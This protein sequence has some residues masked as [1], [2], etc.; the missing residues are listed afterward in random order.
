MKPIVVSVIG[1]TAVGKSKLGIEIS[2]RFGGEVINGD[3]MQFYQ[4]FNIG[5]AKVTETEADGVPH[6]LI[7]FLREDDHYS[8]ASFQADLYDRVQHI[9]NRQR[10][11]VVVGG[12]GF[13]IQSALFN[14]N[15]ADVNRD[16][17]YV[18]AAIA[19]IYANGVAPYYEKLQHVDPIQATKIHPHNIRRVVRALEIYERT[20]QT[21]SELEEQQTNDS[22][23]TPYIIGL[24]MS[25]E[26]LYERINRRVDQMIDDGLY[27]EVTYLYEQFGGEI[28]AM[29]GI[30]Y[31]EW[32]PYLRGEISFDSV[33]AS[34]KQHTRRFAKR[35]L[36][37]Y[38]NKM[39]DVHWYTIDPERYEETFETIFSDLAGFLRDKTNSNN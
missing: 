20:G 36:T 4:G 21:M 7:D 22:P 12:T 24:N 26:V 8:A 29:Q 14:F 10:I 3:S 25:R 35:Q 39:S 30:G 9:T 27:D 34:I 17:A 1:P 37:Y 31:K 13:Y 6:H 33:V 23:Y 28:Q 16:D 32:I 38:R 5:T 19:D 11:P 15:F 18:E 2:K